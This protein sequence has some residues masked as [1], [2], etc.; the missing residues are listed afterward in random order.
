VR[1]VHS[2]SGVTILEVLVASF[3][4]G[5]AAVGLALMVSTGYAFIQG[6]GDNRV[7]LFLAQ[8]RIE[9]LR[10]V[11]FDDSALTPNP[12]TAT[13]PPVEVV[14]D[15]VCNGL[16][17]CPHPGY[18]RATSIVC[19]DPTNFTQRVACN[20]ATS[21][22]AKLITVRVETTPTDPKAQ[23]ITLQAARVRL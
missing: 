5:I 19:V 2:Q 20:P 8:Q 9:Q 16:T 12:L 10:A 21:A 14:E 23:P 22:Q 3:I 18:R 4:V 15:P 6:E 1:H 7:S 17:P 11:G 13:D